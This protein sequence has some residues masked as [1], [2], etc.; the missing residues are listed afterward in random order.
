MYGQ[1][2][3][4]SHCHVW[5]ASAICGQPLP[6]MGSHCH[7]LAAIAMY[8]QPYMGSHCHAWAVIAMHGQPMPCMGSHC[9]VWA[10]IA[11]YGQPLRM[12]GQPL[13]MGTD[14][15]GKDEGT[16]WLA[17]AQ[18]LRI[19]RGADQ[20]GDPGGDPG[21]D[22]G[23]DPVTIELT[24]PPGTLPADAASCSIPADAPSAIWRR[25]TYRAYKACTPARM[26]SQPG[27]EPSG[28]R[29]IRDQNHLG[30]KPSEILGSDWN[31][32]SKRQGELA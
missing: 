21:G 5:A 26:V 11:M 25:C 7:V 29:T 31:I 32:A 24:R 1:P 17:H 4:G 9:H 19:L 8:G 14:P 10:V 22:L 27:S 12:Y 15:R 6:C 20:G 28:I 2:Y 3:M 13:R 16:T 30:S 18:P 23:G